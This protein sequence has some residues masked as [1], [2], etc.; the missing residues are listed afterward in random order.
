MHRAKSSH[1]LSSHG[2][3]GSHI[4]YNSFSPSSLPRVTSSSTSFHSHM[5]HV[6]TSTSTHQSPWHTGAFS[7][8]LDPSGVFY[9]LIPY[10]IYASSLSHTADFTLSSPHF[11]HLSSL[12]SASISWILPSMLSHSQSLL[13]WSVL[14]LRRWTGK[15]FLKPEECLYYSTNSQNSRCWKSIQTQDRFKWF[16][17]WCNTVST[18]SRW[19]SMAPSSILL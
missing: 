18:G 5:A 7:N 2:L 11:K 15:G 19:Q 9:W 12:E 17:N 13:K 4:S 6:F 8:W 1:C 10:K 14:D 16:R 3:V